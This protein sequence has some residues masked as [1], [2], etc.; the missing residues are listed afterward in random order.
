MLPSDRTFD[1]LKLGVGTHNWMY[2]RKKSF[3][4]SCTWYKSLL[5][6]RLKNFLMDWLLVLG[7]K[8]GLVECAIV[9]VK[10]EVILSWL[11][12]HWCVAKLKWRYHKLVITLAFHAWD[13]KSP[14]DHEHHQ[15]SWWCQC[16]DKSTNIM[17]G[18]AYYCIGYLPHFFML[19]LCCKNA[20]YL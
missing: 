19:V 14:K 1:I 13:G 10:S 5:T 7:L 15:G 9:C 16:S 4:V 6:A 3:N 17:Y 18:S 8:E 12:A 2:V 11:V 20:K